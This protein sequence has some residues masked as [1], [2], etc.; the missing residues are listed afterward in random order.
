MGLPGEAINKIKEALKSAFFNR[1]KL[2]MMLRTQLD[3]EESDVSDNDDY[4]LVIFE[5]ITKL[6]KQER[7]IELVEGALRE[8]P[9]NSKLQA[10]PEVLREIIH[11]SLQKNKSDEK[12]KIIFQEIN[13]LIL[14]NILISLE[15]DYIDQ[16]QQAYIACCFEDLRT[17]WEGENPNTAEGILVN[18][19]DTP[20][21][22]SSET[23]VVQFVA[24]LFESTEIP[25]E[26]AKKL[27]EWG[28]KNANNFYNLLSQLKADTISREEQKEIIPT[29]LI[30]LIQPSEQHR[31]KRYFVW[32]WFISDGRNDKFNYQ[33]GEG[34][35]V[36]E[37]QDQEKETFSLSEA[38]RLI[39]SY[40]NQVTSYLDDLSSQP[41]IEI[42][43]PYELLNEP[44][45]S[46]EIQEEDELPIPIGSSYT[47]I[48][49]SSNRLRKYRYRNIWVQKWKTLKEMTET[50]C[51]QYFISGEYNSW[52]E[53]Y[54]R[55]NHDNALALKL[56]RPPSKEFFKVINQTAIPVA[57]WLR[58]EL[59]SSDFHCEVNELL[60]CSIKELPERVKQKRL[61]DFPYDSE[62]RLGHH[63]SLLWENPYLLPPQ[64]EYTT[65]S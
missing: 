43:L 28:E 39:K 47:V 12:L 15:K 63:L 30:V 53:L 62:Q 5:L 33:T 38:S 17:D 9:G 3:I 1:K 22:K 29:Y 52:K 49:R 55:L 34:Y 2:L 4:D 42:F 25:P 24:H 19:K 36:L 41:K 20:Q 11:K 46:W 13:I 16:M 26:T 57:F 14:K 8:V 37:I 32:A 61:D 35:K 44:I 65:P 58:Q 64:I 6:E 31:N 48:I 7:I 18:L 51:S 56:I 50:T 10:L 60:K 40:I 45:D 21:G 27:K 23:P 54:S 59:K